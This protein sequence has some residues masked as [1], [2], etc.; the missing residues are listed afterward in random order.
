VIETVRVALA[1]IAANK[2]RSAL[3][4][5]GLTI[6]VG[7]VIVLIAVGTGS[8]SAV[9]K[10]ID[11]LGSN[12][13]LVSSTPTLGGLRRGGAVTVGSSLTLADSAALQNKFEAPDVQSSSPVV[14]AN[15]VTLEY[16]DTTY[17]PS[18]FV[19]TTPSYQ[20]ARS[21]TMA[22]GTWFSGAEERRHSR[23]L[24][25][26]PTV[27]SELFGGQDPV[28]QTI[29]L[30][31]TNFSIV[32]VTQSKGSN[33][34]QNQD[35]VAIA[36]LSAVQDSLTG[37]GS[38]NQIVVQ[39]K[40]RGQ[41]GAAQTEVTEILNRLDP[42]SAG[43]TTSNFN[44]LNQ[45][46]I[47]QTSTASSKVFTTLL[48][49]VAAISLLVGGIGVMNIMLVS[50]TERTREIGIR[51]AVGA[52]RSDI[53]FQFLVEAVLV[54]L[55]GGISGVLAGVIGSQFKIA[56]VQPVIA[57]YS[58]GLA[59]GA[60]VL[61]GLFFGTYPAGRAAALRPIEALRFE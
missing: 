56:G 16:N 37:Y 35:D 46:S 44:V 32:G 23:V 20:Q 7:S 60:A 21:Y 8:S 4:I 22:E 6:G 55:F 34:S 51:K 48:G 19:G 30:N 1:G 5:L 61:T 47:L 33:G 59:F 38:I 45:S 50:V 28:G 52:R 24:V 17:S 2:L 58:I 29:Q 15:G 49:E 3:T 18:S 14:S 41:L 40:S 27:A 25:I 42:P 39:A 54:S 43:S 12:V 31:D 10:Q 9:Q 36:P 53:L 57:P 26:G 11:A 13:L